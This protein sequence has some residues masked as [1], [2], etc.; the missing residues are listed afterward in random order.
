MFFYKVNCNV[1]PLFA[2][3]E[4]NVEAIEKKTYKTLKPKTKRAASGIT[5]KECI[6]VAEIAYD[7]SLT[8]CIISLE[9]VTD[10]CKSAAAFLKSARIELL[11]AES[12]E[13]TFSEFDNFLDTAE[14]NRYAPRSYVIYDKFGIPHEDIYPIRFGENTVAPGTEDELKKS[15]GGL[16]VSTDLVPEIDRVFKGKKQPKAKGHPV[17]YIMLSEN[18]AARRE[19]TR[20]LIKSLYSAGRIK[21]CR[22]SFY[23]VN[24]RDRHTYSVIENIY[25]I[26]AG[27]TAVIRIN[28]SNDSDSDDFAAKNIFAQKMSEMMAEYKDSVLTILC[29]PLGETKFKECITDMLDNIAIV[30]ISEDKADCSRSREYLKSKAHEAGIRV[31]KKLYA[32]ITDESVLTVTELDVIFSEWHADKL[33][34]AVYP[35][36][37]ETK[38][39]RKKLAGKKP[40]GYAAKT[41]DEMTGLSA[42]KKVMA[43]AVNYYKMQKLFKSRGLNSGRPSMHMVFTG[44]PG[45]AKTTVARL[46]AQ[47]MRENGILSSG[48]LVEVGRNDLVGQFVGWTAPTIVKKFKQAKGGVLFI[49]EAYSLV[50]DRS[51]SFGD[52]AINTIVQQMENMRDDLIVIFAGY[53]DQMEHFLDKNP[54]L[55][56]RI[57]FHVPFEDYT[58][59]ELCEIAKYICKNDDYTLTDGALK[60]L[61]LL[62]DSARTSPDFGNGRFVRNALEKARMA[63]ASRLLGSDTGSLTNADLLTICEQDIE[64]APVKS[65]EAIPFRMGF[66]G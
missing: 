62:F 10:A 56:S 61:A 35:Q 59:V 20:C 14:D 52:E 54:G 60:K 46:F 49:D 51:G 25:K 24:L 39:A 5:K 1:K 66:A 12:S 34:N 40:V 17:H 29:L 55:R 32:K 26:S 63:Q 33:L 11:S 57:A 64:E 8:L 37:A 22:Y 31:D 4:K 6:F 3:S 45:T 41:L 53:P 9:P 21:S 23:D 13:I 2:D 7:S 27:G 44:N 16:F 65:A 36:Y 18:T 28:A 48:H 15:A 47:I 19:G 58:T 50:D 43:D 38:I 42:A 30:E